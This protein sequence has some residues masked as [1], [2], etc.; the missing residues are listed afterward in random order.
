MDGLTIFFIFFFGIAALMPLLWAIGAA[1]R[2]DSGFWPAIVGAGWAIVL[3]LVT[4]IGIGTKWG[5]CPV[6]GGTAEGSVLCFAK[7]GDDEPVCKPD[8]W[9]VECG[10]TKTCPDKKNPAGKPIP[11]G[12]YC[13]AGQIAVFPFCERVQSG[14]VKQPWATWSDLSFVAAGLWLLWFLHY[15]VSPETLGT[16]DNPM[17]QIGWLS[18]T[19]GFIV[20]FMGPPSQWYHA[21][22]K[23]WAGWFDAM[24]VVTW[25]TFNAVYVFYAALA[26]MWGRGRGIARPITILCFWGGWVTMFGLWAIK[27]SARI[28]TYV[29]SGGLWGAAEL[30]YLGFGIW[31]KP[32]YRRTWWLFVINLG[33]LGGTMGLWAAF[34][35]ALQKTDCI[36]RQDFPGHALFHI[37]ASLSTMLTFASFA[38]ERK[39][40]K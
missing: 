28:W 18:V 33:L 39:V 23:E 31:G 22:L 35:D 4:F 24:S 30:L 36:D 10:Q 40:T 29:V 11:A 25:L 1:I 34:H 14:G 27:P 6:S 38:S 9:K 2:G 26:A 15:F 5:G 7:K 17:R 37:L 3:L 32:K 21:S 16:E 13:P 8:L 12:K 19:Y 20:I